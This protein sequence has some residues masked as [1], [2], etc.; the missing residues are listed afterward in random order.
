MRQP[1]NEEDG[2]KDVYWITRVLAVFMHSDMSD[3]AELKQTACSVR[4]GNTRDEKQRESVARGVC[5]AKDDALQETGKFRSAAVVSCRP[6]SV[7]LQS[8]EIH[9]LCFRVNL[10]PIKTNPHPSSPGIL[11]RKNSAL[12]RTCLA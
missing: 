2:K 5:V 4:E 7:R 8:Q 3:R 6:A 12:G 11:Y 1:I 10:S 9:C